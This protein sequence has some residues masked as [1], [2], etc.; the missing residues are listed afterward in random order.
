MCVFD[1][2]SDFAFVFSISKMVC[3][4]LLGCL[5]TAKS[6]HAFFSLNRA[7]ASHHT[8]KIFVQNFLDESN[9]IGENVFDNIQDDE[10]DR[11]ILDVDISP[12]IP[13]S[14]EL[15]DKL[16]NKALEQSIKSV[17]D[18]FPNELLLDGNDLYVMDSEVPDNELIELV[19]SDEGL[20]YIPK[21][22]IRMQKYYMRQ[23][24]GLYISLNTSVQQFV[25]R[26]N[27]LNCYLLYFPEENPKQL[28][29]DEIIEI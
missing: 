11:V 26:L 19:L 24:R 23:P 9:F 21:R 20:E 12:S 18:E 5:F 13:T 25:E 22:D 4:V 29:Q 6:I 7:I 10:T 1:D 27:D 16:L 8:R 14:D 28:D 2:T 15:I 17:Q 3:L